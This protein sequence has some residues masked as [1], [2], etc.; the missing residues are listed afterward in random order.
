MGSVNGGVNTVT[1]CA[2]DS[3]VLTLGRDARALAKTSCVGPAVPVVRR[4]VCCSASTDGA[5]AA[6][7]CGRREAASA[8]YRA[9]HAQLRVGAH[10]KYYY[11]IQHAAPRART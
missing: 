6:T 2:F 5:L 9:S 7:Y 1:W 4:A 11:F 3:F 10:Y 8:L